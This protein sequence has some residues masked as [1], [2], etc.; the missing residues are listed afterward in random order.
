VKTGRDMAIADNK[1]SHHGY[2]LLSSAALH[3]HNQAW[4]Q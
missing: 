2:L 1:L 3:R 4:S